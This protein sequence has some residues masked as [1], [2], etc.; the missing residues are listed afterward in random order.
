MKNKEKK[1]NKKKKVCRTTVPNFFGDVSGNKELFFTPNDISDMCRSYQT[2]VP[3]DDDV[4]GEHV[5]SRAA[6]IPVP[7]NDISLL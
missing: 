6:L 4:G 5:C 3:D 1:V 7:R 2:K